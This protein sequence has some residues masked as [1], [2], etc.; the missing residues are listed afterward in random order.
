MNEKID[1]TDILVGLRKIIRSINLESKKIEKEFGISIPQLLCLNYLKN[2]VDFKST[3]TQLKKYMNLNASTIS[4]IVGRLEKKGLLARLPKSGDKRVSHIVITSKG[5]ELLEGIP[6]LLHDQ[7]SS[8]LKQ[9]PSSE[10]K[11][12]SK[13]I[14]ILIK[15]MGAEDIDASPVIMV[16]DPSESASE[17]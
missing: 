7:L 9:L 14:D 16:K 5:S 6:S 3:S 4:G 1:Y 11:D 17:E 13:S 2:Q 8:K 10:L 12:I 15:F